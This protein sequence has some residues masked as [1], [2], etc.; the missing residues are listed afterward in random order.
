MSRQSL[1]KQRV[2]RV[3][4]AE[5][6]AGIREGVYVLRD[7]KHTH[8]RVTVQFYPREHWIVEDINIMGGSAIKGTERRLTDDDKAKLESWL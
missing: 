6:R 7:A 3:A 2:S 1:E 5:Q 4:K 8:V